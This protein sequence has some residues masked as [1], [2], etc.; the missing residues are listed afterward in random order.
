LNYLKDW[1]AQR[2]KVACWYNKALN[3]VGDLILP[4]LHSDA[5]HVYHLYVVRTKH[6]DALQ[7]HLYKKGIGT[8]IHYPIPPHLQE[9]YRN[10]N[11]KKGQLPIAEQLADEVLSLPI[12]PGMEEAL[13]EKVTS[14]IKTAFEQWI[15]TEL[16]FFTE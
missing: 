10:L 14:E 4:K 7:Q 1:T 3:G 2:Q 15:Y 13:V 12:W 11:I 8:L 5:T 6:R 9:A 16:K